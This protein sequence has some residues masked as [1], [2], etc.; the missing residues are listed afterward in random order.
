MPLSRRTFLAGAIAAA[1]RPTV[2]LPVAAPVA[3][4]GWV[5]ISDYNPWPAAMW[6]ASD[7]PV[8]L[9]GPL[10][11]GEVGRFESFRFIESPLRRA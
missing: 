3:A 5:H 6:D 4:T 10:Y 8:V 11:R 2:L 7:Q 9:T 1:F